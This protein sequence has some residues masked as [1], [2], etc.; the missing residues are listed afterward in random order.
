MR[1][2]ETNVI[3]GE[4]HSNETA[5]DGD[6]SITAGVFGPKTRRMKKFK[7]VYLT[8][9]EIFIPIRRYVNQT[10]STKNRSESSANYFTSTTHVSRQIIRP[11]GFVCTKVPKIESMHFKMLPC[12]SLS[13]SSHSS[14]LWRIIIQKVTSR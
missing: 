5:E 12:V 8:I 11:N 14:T 1:A 6:H 2:K 3:I 4:R 13:G 10:T 9:H 7:N